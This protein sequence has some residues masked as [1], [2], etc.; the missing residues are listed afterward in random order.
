MK[1]RVVFAAALFATACGQSTSSGSAL[2]LNEHSNYGLRVIGFDIDP[3]K[4]QKIKAGKSYINYIPDSAIRAATSATF[5]LPSS[6]S[7]WRRTLT[8]PSSISRSPTTSM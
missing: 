6:P 5:S 7:R 3:A 1:K 4:A 2:T 8:V